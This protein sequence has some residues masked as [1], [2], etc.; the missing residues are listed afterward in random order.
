MDLNFTAITPKTSLFIHYEYT[1]ITLN[2]WPVLHRIKK[3]VYCKWIDLVYTNKCLHFRCKIF[4]TAITPKFETFCTPTLHHDD[5][6]NIAVK[7]PI[8]HHDDTQKFNQKSTHIT[9]WWH[10]KYKVSAAGKMPSFRQK[11]SLSKYLS[12]QWN[13]LK[14]ALKYESKK[15]FS[16]RVY[17]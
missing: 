7:A 10:Q 5:T 8:L 13:S 4:Y 11:G 17:P 3:S 15:S 12:Q 1:C 16:H 6:K 14:N 2:H 9:P